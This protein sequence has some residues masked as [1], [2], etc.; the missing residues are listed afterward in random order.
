ME[1]LN[2]NIVNYIVIISLI[3]IG[4]YLGDALSDVI[5][6]RLLNGL[7]SYQGPTALRLTLVSVFSGALS[8]A[9]AVMYGEYFNVKNRNKC[10]STTYVF[11]ILIL[12]AGDLI[13]LGGFSL[14]YWFYERGIVIITAFIV[15]FTYSF[16]SERPT[17]L[18][19]S[20]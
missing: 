12:M 14:E 20:G 4:L 16:I 15:I 1:S 13:M 19:K 11:Y 9:L 10:Y 6:Y 18:G 8:S 17:Q 2:K 5:Y 7:D 3:L